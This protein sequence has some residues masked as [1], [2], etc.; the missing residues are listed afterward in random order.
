MVGSL[1]G[2]SPA[3]TRVSTGCGAVS[4]VHGGG[5][6]Q[7]LQL[8]RASSPHALYLRFP[9][10]QTGSCCYASTGSPQK[11]QQHVQNTLHGT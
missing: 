4:F 9:K 10:K 6:Q 7:C 2:Q 11:E 1:A 8:T 3:P 5:A